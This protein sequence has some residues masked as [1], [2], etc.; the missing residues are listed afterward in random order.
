MIEPWSLI[1]RM[2]QGR[3]WMTKS[4]I[5]KPRLHTSNARTGHTHC[6]NAIV[7]PTP[8]SVRTKPTST[9]P[10]PTVDSAHMQAADSP[11]TRSL[12]MRTSKQTSRANPC[13]NNAKATPAT[14]TPASDDSGKCVDARATTA[15]DNPIKAASIFS[16][17]GNI[18][19]IIKGGPS[20]DGARANNTTTTAVI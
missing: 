7:P 8:A 11:G 16:A 6:L 10:S 12:R 14:S 2:A 4:F 19:Q 1:L 20:V 9:P 17:R 5:M 18:T 13:S 3:H 15:T